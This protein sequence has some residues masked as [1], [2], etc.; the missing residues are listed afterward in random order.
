MDFLNQAVGQAD[1]LVQVDDSRRP[2]HGRAAAGDGR[3]QPGVSRQSASAAVEHAYLM[4]GEPFSAAQLPSWKPPSPKPTSATTQIEGNRIRVPLG[5]AIGLYGCA[6]RRRRIAADFG[7]YLEKVG[8]HQSLGRQGA[9]QTGDQNRQAKRIAV[10]L[11]NMQG[12]ESAA[13]MYDVE[14]TGPFGK[15]RSRDRFGQRQAVDWH[16]AGREQVRMIRHT[17]ATGYRG[18][19][20]KTSP[21]PI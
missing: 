11:S 15:R 20:P 3:D 5:Q 7:K 13:V 8:R 1:R 16:A 9:A 19:S 14:E 17:V 10:D 18:P 12:I 6:G 4:G 2:H 21:S